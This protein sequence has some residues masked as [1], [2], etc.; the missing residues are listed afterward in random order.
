[1]TGNPGGEKKIMIAGQGR[2]REQARPLLR[3]ER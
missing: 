1:M 2:A 3:K